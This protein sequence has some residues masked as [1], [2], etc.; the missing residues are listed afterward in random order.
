MM[1]TRLALEW[2]LCPPIPKKQKAPLISSGA[3]D[4]RYPVGFLPIRRQPVLGN[5]ADSAL[6]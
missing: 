3:D 6:W 4:Q 5:D 2:A 1:A